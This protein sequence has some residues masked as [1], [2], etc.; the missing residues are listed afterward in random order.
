LEECIKIFEGKVK[1]G[2]GNMAGDSRMA[3]VLNVNLK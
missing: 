2:T 3:A 1:A